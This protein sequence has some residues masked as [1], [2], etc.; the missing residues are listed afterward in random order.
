MQKFLVSVF[1]ATIILWGAFLKVIL[2]YEPNSNLII[3]LGILL[4]W[5][6]ATFTAS[7]I[8]YFYILYTNRTSDKRVKTILDRPDVIIDEKVLY[9]RLFKKSAL[10]SGIVVALITVRILVN[11]N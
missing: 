2:E 4:L 8:W 6:V 1:I 3:L 9:R 5:G 10:I 11:L 7:L